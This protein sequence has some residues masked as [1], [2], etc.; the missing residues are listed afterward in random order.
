MTKGLYIGSRKDLYLKTCLVKLNVEDTKVVL[1]QF[2]DTALEEAYG[3]H[4][5]DIENIKIIYDGEE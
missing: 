1:C 5:F 2:D 4:K 3:W